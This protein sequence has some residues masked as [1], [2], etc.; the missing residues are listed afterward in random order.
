LTNTNQNEI[1]VTAFSV[2]PLLQKSDFTEICMV[3][4]EM[5]HVD[6]CDLLIMHSFYAHCARN[7]KK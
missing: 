5:K 2:N 7:T 3:G 4:L 6:E 1:F